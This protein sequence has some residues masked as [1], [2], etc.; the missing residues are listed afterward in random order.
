MILLLII[1]IRTQNTNN[2]ETAKKNGIYLLT[3]RII[4]LT[5]SSMLNSISSIIANRIKDPFKISIKVASKNVEF[6]YDNSLLDIHRQVNKNKIA[7]S[8]L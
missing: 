2:A 3:S 4:C 6:V 7:T 8:F 1:S 5:T